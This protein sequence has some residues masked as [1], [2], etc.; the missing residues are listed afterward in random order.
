MAIIKSFLWSHLLH[1][2]WP[3][4]L[5]FPILSKGRRP[6]NSLNSCLVPDWY[7]I[8]YR[9][10][11]IISIQWKKM[12]GGKRNRN[13]THLKSLWTPT[14]RSLSLRSKDNC[15]TSLFFFF[16]MAVT[17]LKSYKIHVMVFFLDWVVSYFLL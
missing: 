4:Y 9:L 17:S 2:M 7:L 5:G 3:S 15:I 8:W 6:S 13:P 1:R 10:G 16:K 14:A 11:W 12:K